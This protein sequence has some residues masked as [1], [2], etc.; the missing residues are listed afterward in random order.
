MN[1]FTGAGIFVIG[2]FVVRGIAGFREDY[3]YF[4]KEKFTITKYYNYLKSKVKKG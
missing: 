1:G 4:K 2:V 3:L